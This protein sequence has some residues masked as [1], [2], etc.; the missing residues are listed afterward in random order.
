MRAIGRALA[1]F[2]GVVVLAF[3]L[4]RLLPGDPVSMLG[5][6]PGMGPEALQELRE[7]AG[8]GQSVAAQFLGYAGG[9]LQGDLGH[10][11]ST[12]Q[13]VATEIAR[14]L[15]ASLELALA[16]FLLA[17]AV[18]LGLGLGI[19]RAPG[20]W[21]DRLA[22]VVVA[23]GAALP[24]FV[25]G[26]LLI[27]L[28]YVGL[29]LSAAPFGRYP[30]LMALPMPRSGMLLPDALLAG[31]WPALAAALAH[32][33]LPAATL[34]IF[35]LAPM[36]RVLRTALL[37]ALDGPGVHGARALGL[38]ERV[39]LWRY[40]LPEAFGP[41]LPIALL[42]FGYMLGAGVLVEKVFAWPGIGRYALE[43]LGVLDYPPVQ[44]VMLVLAALHVGLALLAGVVGRWL[45]PRLGQADG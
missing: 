22:R 45:D 25:T 18:V 4:T 2:I 41:L 3:A 20:G 31:D 37:A 27:Q 10:S 36:L 43:A 8:L 28:F 34:A 29:G 32:L 42:T 12:G 13:P 40:A 7:A 33:A 6:A 24:L 1:A 15:P 14:R 17:L 19:A 11:V 39:V 26:L 35:A 30:A 21:V 5:A 9:L 44:G 16:G 38:P 23:F